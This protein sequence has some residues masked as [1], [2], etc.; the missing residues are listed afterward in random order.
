MTDLQAVE[1]I[2]RVA[3]P[4]ISPDPDEPETDAQAEAADASWKERE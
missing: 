4:W 1:I 3:A 2:K